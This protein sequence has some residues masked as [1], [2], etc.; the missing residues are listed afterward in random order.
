MDVALLVS[1]DRGGSRGV[2]VL[3]NRS[4]DAAA[5]EGRM[6]LPLVRESKD[7]K[8][9]AIA[10]DHAAS[11]PSHRLDVLA[12]RI[13]LHLESLVPQGRARCLDIGRGD[14]TLVE[15]VQAR[16]SRT[17]WRCIDVHE[18]ATIPY[19]DDEFDVA[20][21]CDVLHQA[22]EDAAKLLAEAGRV[23]RHVLVKDNFEYGPYSRTM[24]Q[25][26]DLVGNLR[27]GA[28]V[29]ERYFTREGFVRLASQQQ[30][31]ITALDA[32]LDLYEHVPGMNTLLRRDWQFIAVLRCH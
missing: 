2:H 21:L 13:A 25:L 12:D 15:A 8:N 26:V 9:K 17:D 29:P 28:G 4:F 31:V 3:F 32:D 27:D 7:E 11:A 19:A 1:K 5:E 18:M 6:S 23:A 22:P 16:A 10:S 14:M 20:L 30:L 24:L